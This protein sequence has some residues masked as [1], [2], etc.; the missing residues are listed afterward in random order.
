MFFCKC[1]IETQRKY[2]VK[3]LRES[4][5]SFTKRVNEIWLCVSTFVSL[6]SICTKKIAERVPCH[7]T[8]SLSTKGKK[9]LIPRNAPGIWPSPPVKGQ[10]LPRKLLVQE[11]GDA[12]LGKRRPPDPGPV[13][14]DAGEGPEVADV[15]PEKVAAPEGVGGG[16]GGVQK[17]GLFVPD[18]VGAVAPVFAGRRVELNKKKIRQCR[19]CKK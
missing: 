12:A 14:V 1:N 2:E 10:I 9:L 3:S 4:W 19:V 13:V 17:V 15:H 6:I 8:H 11:K 7:V 16:G 5:N 18:E